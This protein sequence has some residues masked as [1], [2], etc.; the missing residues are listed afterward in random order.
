MKHRKVF[1]SPE[2]ISDLK[3]GRDFTTA[4]QRKQVIIFLPA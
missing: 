3:S 1:L 2:A 4:I